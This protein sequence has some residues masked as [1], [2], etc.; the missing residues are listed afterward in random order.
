MSNDAVDIAVTIC[1]AAALWWL[2]GGLGGCAHVPAVCASP[3]ISTHQPV[4]ETMLRA[5]W[6]QRFGPIKPAC[7]SAL[8]WIVLAD[9]ELQQVCGPATAGCERENHGCPVAFAGR[10]YAGDKGLFA[11]ELAHRLSGCAWGDADHDHAN[12]DVWGIGGWV[13]TMRLMLGH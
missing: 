9:T 13:P 6:E 1:L 12:Q 10:G 11:H 4:A 7:D 2:V 5:Q 8:P 3:S